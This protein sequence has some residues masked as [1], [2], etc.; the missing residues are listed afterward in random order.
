MHAESR[1]PNCALIHFEIVWGI[2]S[3]VPEL[4]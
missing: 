4:L 1:F 2:L 3:A